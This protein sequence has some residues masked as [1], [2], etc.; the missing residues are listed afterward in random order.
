[1]AI[2]GRSVCF[3]IM[4]GELKE[5]FEFGTLPLN[6]ILGGAVYVLYKDNKEMRGELFEAYKKNTKAIAEWVLLENQRKK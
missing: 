3:I 1:M 6:V 2:I 4:L 5:I